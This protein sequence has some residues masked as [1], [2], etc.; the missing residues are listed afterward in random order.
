MNGRGGVEFVC[1][2]CG[3]GSLRIVA[4]TEKNVRVE[5]LSCGK[6]SVI[7]RNAVSIPAAKPES[8]S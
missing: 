2:H 6:E 8:Q 3:G 7:Q 5:C 1:G 4:V